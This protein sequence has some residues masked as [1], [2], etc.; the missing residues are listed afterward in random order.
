M[1]APGGG[2]FLHR[3]A[4]SLFSRNV[5]SPRA[6]FNRSMTQ[7]KLVMVALLLALGCG[8]AVR[9]EAPRAQAPPEKFAGQIQGYT[10]AAK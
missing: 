1:D 8:T 6:V 10:D 7:L 5:P 4:R 9:A 2:G 3:S